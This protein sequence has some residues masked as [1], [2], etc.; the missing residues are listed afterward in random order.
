MLSSLSACTA[1]SSSFFSQFT[2][3]AVSTPDAEYWYYIDIILLQYQRNIKVIVAEYWKA[4]KSF[5]WLKYDSKSE[6]QGALM[7]F[8]YLVAYF[9]LEALLKVSPNP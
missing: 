6:F 9:G 4:N 3:V 2:L 5:L 1:S 7:S 8:N